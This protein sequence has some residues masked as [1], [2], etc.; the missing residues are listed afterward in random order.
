M[1]NKVKSAGIMETIDQCRKSEVFAKANQIFQQ[2]IQKG[3]TVVCPISIHSIDIVRFG[4]DG[5]RANVQCVFCERYHKKIAVQCDRRGPAS[6][7]WNYSNLR[8][9]MKLHMKK[10]IEA[11]PVVYS[12]DT[13]EKND[14]YGVQVKSK[15]NT[16]REV[17]KHCFPTPSTK[18]HNQQKVKFKT[19]KRS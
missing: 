6:E 14:L 9:H 15:P 5:V 2:F 3:L 12:C 13:T 8:K 17:F 10:Q 19:F 16:S 7:Y 11:L 18:N 4:A 1:R